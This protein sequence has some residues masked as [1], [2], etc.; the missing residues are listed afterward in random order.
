MAVDLGSN[1][2][3]DRVEKKR[4]DPDRPKPGGARQISAHP[5]VLIFKSLQPFGWGSDGA[6][7][8][9]LLVAGYGRCGRLET[10][11][12]ACGMSREVE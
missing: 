6:V 1:R 4:F 11:R 8:A 10:E 2:P 3:V 5:S 12:V 9:G 7:D